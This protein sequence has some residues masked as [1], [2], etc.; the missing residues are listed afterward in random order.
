MSIS[1]NTLAPLPLPTAEVPHRSVIKSG[2]SRFQEITNASFASAANGVPSEAV[3][4]V[5]SKD[6]K[7]F[8]ASL[9]P[10]NSAAITSYSV[11]ASTGMKKNINLGSIIDKKG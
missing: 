8:F 11:Y 6:E 10:E 1:V 7:Q 2:E 5:V 3:N 4:D 9:F